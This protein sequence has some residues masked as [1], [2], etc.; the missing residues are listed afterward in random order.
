LLF[1]AVAPFILDSA[2]HSESGQVVL[3]GL[4]AFPVG[5]WVGHEHPGMERHVYGVLGAA[6]GLLTWI[7]MIVYVTVRYPDAPLFWEVWFV[8]YGLLVALVFLGGALCGDLARRD[9][10][11]WSSGAVPAAIACLGPLLALIDD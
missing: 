4:A 7:A 5:L 9:Q 3:L 6:L 2:T 8:R 10:L 11:T 1:A